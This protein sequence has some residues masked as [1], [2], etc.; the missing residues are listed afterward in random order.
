VKSPS[1]FPRVRNRRRTR[2]IVGASIAGVV[3][4]AAFVAYVVQVASS[5]PSEVNLGDEVFPVGSAERF[6]DRIAADGPIL[7]KD[8]LTPRA[9]REVYVQHLGTDV[10]EGWLAIDAYPPDDR[11]L[12]CL[13][14]WKDDEF[15]DPCG[16]GSF[17]A[18]GSGLRTYPG[19]VDDRGIVVIDLRTRDRT[20]TGP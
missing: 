3:L 17:P 4:T 16:G 20:G 18:D 13:L 14:Q 7:F 11:R 10:E 2:L 19:D 5:R 8:P 9:G 6:A 1:D 15:Q 12:A